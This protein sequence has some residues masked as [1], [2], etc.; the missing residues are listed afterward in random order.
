MPVGFLAVRPLPPYL[1]YF[2][3]PHTTAAVDRAEERRLR[4]F[5]GQTDSGVPHFPLSMAPIML[6]VA[7]GEASGSF[8]TKGHGTRVEPPAVAEL[9]ARIG[10]LGDT[11]GDDEATAVAERLADQALTLVTRETPPEARSLIRLL[12][13]GALLNRTQPTPWDIERAI[14]VLSQAIVKDCGPDT[15]PGTLASIH[16]DLARAYARRR[17]GRPDLNEHLA[18]SHGESAV[19][20]FERSGDRLAWAVCASNLATGLIATRSGERTSCLE[21]AVALLEAA[22]EVAPPGHREWCDIA[23]NLGQA[24]AARATGDDMVNFAKARQWYLRVAE[25]EGIDDNPR[26]YGDTHYKLG[27]LILKQR[28][29]PQEALIHLEEAQRG[30]ERASHGQLSSVHLGMSTAYAM[31]GRSADHIAALEKAQEFRSP[32][33]HPA[34]WARVHASLAAARMDTGSLT[35]LAEGTAALHEALEALERAKAGPLEAAMLYDRLSHVWGAR[36]A[37]GEQGARAQQIAELTT[38]AELSRD[39]AHMHR[40]VA[41]KLGALHAASGDW[42]AAADAYRSAVAAADELFNTMLLDT[43]QRRLLASSATLRHEAC[44]ALARAGRLPEAVV[45]AESARARIIGQTLEQTN[46]DLEDVKAVHPAAYRA[47]ADAAERF[48]AVSSLNRDFLAEGDGDDV[49]ARALQLS[50]ELTQ[51]REALRKAISRIQ[52]LPG[53]AQFL[54]RAD[55]G[56][57]AARTGTDTAMSYVIATHRGSAALLVTTGTGGEP[58]AV[59]VFDDVTSADVAEAVQAHA[60]PADAA[61]A[62]VVRVRGL[63]T[64]LAAAIPERIVRLDLI[65]CG[66]LGLL[67]VHQGALGRVHVSYALSAQTMR[68][69]DPSARRVSVLTVGDPLGD[70]EAAA[71]EARAVARL[72]PRPILLVGEA[73]RIEEVLRHLREDRFDIVHLACHGFYDDSG[74]LSSGLKLADGPL[75]LRA[76]LDD[77]ARTLRGTRLVVMSACESAVVGTENPDEAL[78]LPAAMAQ[79]GAACVVGSLWRVDDIATQ[80]L[81]I[82]FHELL[83]GESEARIDQALAEAQRWLAEATPPV[84]REKLP[85]APGTRARLN[86]FDDDEHPFGDPR[87]WAAFVAVGR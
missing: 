36:H 59:A 7:G 9:M 80:A 42:P 30:Y 34:E 49:Q 79:A 77:R 64:K 1:V 14:G 60:D 37:L 67:P 47:F 17:C 32:E 22:V 63:M 5:L 73:A 2:A 16:S 23:S 87:Y 84:L 50:T 45:M 41:R 13:A 83:R 28:R 15:P 68:V 85:M 72:A 24:H 35:S 81:M 76:L 48:A 62:G 54:K 65:A 4:Q 58:A 27:M 3:P 29:D 43:S 55:F 12:L 33:L 56:E 8:R 57:I 52:G 40:E 18:R 75:T 78:G 51:A 39:N 20:L 26:G 86:L 38:A 44:H 66:R 19:E 46:A 21:R 53:K 6:G 31:L 10:A 25:A 70:M 74:P 82:R 61:M 71:E 11:R 69:H